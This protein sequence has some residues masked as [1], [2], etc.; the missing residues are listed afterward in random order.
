MPLDPDDDTDVNT[1]RPRISYHAVPRRKIEIIKDL[2]VAFVVDMDLPFSIFDNKFLS[3]IFYYFD[4]AISTQ[5]P[6]SRESIRRHT[7][8]LF[9]SKKENIRQ[10]LRSAITKIHLGFDLWTSPN[11]Q[12][13]LAVTCHFLDVSGKYQVRLLSLRRQLGA[14]SGQNIATSLLRLL[15]LVIRRGPEIQS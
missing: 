13:Y 11:H 6:W 4:E 1:K 10:Q 9:E 15:G 5:I 14:H 3:E 2:S 7:L 12:A 8:A